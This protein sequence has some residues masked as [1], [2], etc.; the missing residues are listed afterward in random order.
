MEN[1]GAIKIMAGI[2]IRWI[3]GA[4]GDLLCSLLALKNKD[5]YMNIS[6][7]GTIEPETGAVLI[8]NRHD[9]AHPSLVRLASGT[10][11][12]LDPELLKIDIHNLIKK[13]RRF[14]LKSHLFDNEME[15]YTEVVDLGF[16]LKFLPFIVQCNI[17]K[18]NIVVNN[19][20][21]N[22][23]KF[24]ITLQKIIEKLNNEQKKQLI[25]WNLVKDTIKMINKFALD[26][27][28]LNTRD[29][30][31][32]Q[33]RIEDFFKGK[34]YEINFDVQFFSD[35]KNINTKYLPSEKYQ[36]YLQSKQYNYNDKQLAISERYIL[37][38]LSGQRFTFMD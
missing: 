20:A 23:S 26:N 11:D 8:S 2:V 33:K 1:R 22:N 27:A 6:C 15:K 24:D 36:E 34:G 28:S 30:F 13:H 4:G 38:A 35:W 16:D 14:I 21:Y 25:T 9:L 12:S 3:G 17:E 10:A 32:N 5:L 19:F 31:Y 29:F 37:L 7:H 18:T